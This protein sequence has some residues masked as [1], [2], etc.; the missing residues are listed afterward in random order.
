MQETNHGKYNTLSQ[1]VK[2]SVPACTSL[3]CKTESIVKGVKEEW[4]KDYKVPDFGIDHD[5]KTSVKNLDDAEKKLGP[6]VLP[7]EDEKKNLLAQ[8]KKDAKQPVPA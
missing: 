1:K 6:W 7:K 2:D 4:P 5:I 3:G 8:P